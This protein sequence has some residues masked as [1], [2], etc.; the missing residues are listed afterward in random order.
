MICQYEQQSE[1]GGGAKSQNFVYI[2][3]NSGN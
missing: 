2:K 3:Y 1:E